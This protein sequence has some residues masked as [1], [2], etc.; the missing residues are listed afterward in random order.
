MANLIYF[1]Q[2]FVQVDRETSRQASLESYPIWK[3][4]CWGVGGVGEGEGGERKGAPKTGPLMPSGKDPWGEKEGWGGG[5]AVWVPD[6]GSR[7]LLT[8]CS[9]YVF[10]IGVNQA[11]AV[12]LLD[13]SVCVRVCVYV[14][15]CVCVGG[16]LMG[17]FGYVSI[18]VMVCPHLYK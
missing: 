15:V 17:V 6:I 5:V 18:Q 10:G 8:C 4:S 9:N 7:R 13:V 1:A 3:G 12:A 14:C 2:L 11:E 16:G